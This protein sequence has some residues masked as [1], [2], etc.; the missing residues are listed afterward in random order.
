[1]Y[2]GFDGS[3]QMHFHTH[4]H[5]SE[6]PRQTSSPPIRSSAPY[7]TSSANVLNSPSTCP[8]P[9]S[10]SSVSVYVR[11][12]HVCMHMVCG[13]YSFILRGVQEERVVADR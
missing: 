13:V 10:T 2:V 5:T 4:T 1:M 9:Y 8:P 6:G 3:L 7:S 11:L 12:V